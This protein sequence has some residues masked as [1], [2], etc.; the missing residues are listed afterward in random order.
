MRIILKM[1][2]NNNLEINEKKKWEI[3]IASLVHDVGKY[4]SRVVKSNEEEWRNKYGNLFLVE[5]N[6]DELSISF[7][8]EYFPNGIKGNITTLLSKQDKIYSKYVWLGDYVSSQERDLTGKKERSVNKIPLINIFSRISLSKVKDFNEYSFW[9][10][11]KLDYDFNKDV[12]LS[13]KEDF[14]SFDIYKFISF[15]NEIRNLSKEYD[16]EK[17]VVINDLKE[18][19]FRLFK[20]YEKYMIRVPGSAYVDVPDIDLFNHS[21]LSS[22]ISNCLINLKYDEVSELYDEMIDFYVNEINKIDEENIKELKTKL[23]NLSS[24]SLMK[25]KYFLK[26]TGDFSGIQDF[27]FTI[28]SQKAMRNLKVRSFLISYFSNLVSSYIVDKLDYSYSNIVFS[29]GGKFEILL[30]NNEDLKNQVKKIVDDFNK[31]LFN[32]FEGKLFLSLNYDE[33]NVVDF[34]IYRYKTDEELEERNKIISKDNKFKNIIEDKGLEFFVQNDGRECSSCHKTIKENYLIKEYKGL[35]NICEKCKN[36]LDIYE[37][38]FSAQKENRLRNIEIKK[39]NEK[40]NV[41][42]FNSFYYGGIDYNLND[43]KDIFENLSL[44]IVSS[45]DEDKG[46]H[47]LSLEE[48]GKNAKERTGSAYIAGIKLDVD[49][50]GDIFSK[51]FE[52]DNIKDLKIFSRYSVLSY[53]LKYFFEGVVSNLQKN[54]FYKDEIT[55]KENKYSKNIN[56]IYSGGDD[57]FIVGAWDSCL[58]FLRDLR[59]KFDSLVTNDEV[60]FSASYNIFPSK[61]PIIS[62]ANILEEELEN[63]KNDK[64]GEKNKLSI[65]NSK[66]SWDNFMYVEKNVLFLNNLLC[67][68]VKKT[69]K[70]GIIMRVGNSV[71]GIKKVLE[72]VDRD[73]KKFNV[74]A[75]WRLNYYVAREFSNKEEN[76]VSEI[77]ELLSFY[78]ELVKSKFRGEENVELDVLIVASRLAELYTKKKE[79]NQNE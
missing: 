79:G 27:I 77:N 67:N 17:S 35:E 68:I 41:A 9:K 72:S 47:K 59:E 33:M 19:Y 15:L 16:F 4:I 6:H 52:E 21:K 66:M 13:K 14:S 32:N 31:Y 54:G 24:N 40:L 45:E 37:I 49:S 62:I 58:Y 29:S 10:D 69:G 55:G 63:V 18:F 56:I 12:L 8:N 5:K 36:L 74:P 64:S 30:N 70:R 11:V 60:N 53:N 34:S 43:S 50:L 2:K 22:A 65:L 28:D 46:Y 42:D 26:V 51:G 20:L 57:S 7:V 23:E 76:E 71:K 25:K 1:N 38:L 3:I 48:L 75:M 73:N 61:Y 39:I 44:G 78:E